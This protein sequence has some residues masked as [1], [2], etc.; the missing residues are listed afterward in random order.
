MSLNLGGT[1]RYNYFNS[2]VPAGYD[3]GNGLALGVL[4]GLE[5]SDAYFGLTGE[6][7]IGATIPANKGLS[8]TDVFK[9]G[10]VLSLIPAR[11]LRTSFWGAMHNSDYVEAGAQII[12]MP[13][14]GAFCFDVKAWAVANLKEFAQNKNMLINAQI[15][16]SYLF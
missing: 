12:T 2:A 13:G 9:Y 5:S 3:N 6:Y 7:V 4:A 14:T 10:G 15:G 16:L 8:G 1:A 11:G